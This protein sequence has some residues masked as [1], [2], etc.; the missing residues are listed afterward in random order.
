[1]E[2]SNTA[3]TKEGKYLALLPQL[4]ALID[5]KV[6]VTVNLLNLFSALKETMNWFWVGCYY[7]SDNKLLLGAFQG[8]TACTRIDFGKG[9]C[10]KSWQKREVI[11]VDDVNKF[12]GHI[13]CS[14]LTQSELVLPV[15]VNDEVKMV[16]DLDSEQLANF[17]ET[18]VLYMNK[19]ITIIKNHKLIID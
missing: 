2:I 9:V 12:E 5:E 19:V 8:P 3:T 11:C 13:A 15:I 14:N 10:G 17:N 4:A 18:D 1:M 16:I 6:S 7:V